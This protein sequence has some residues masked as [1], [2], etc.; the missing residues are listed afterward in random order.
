VGLD[1]T[2]GTVLERL[3]QAYIARGGNP[4]DISMFLA[5]D[6]DVD[7]SE[8]Q[9]YGGLVAPQSADPGA[10]G[11]YQG[12]WIPLW[13][14][15]PRRL[16][17]NRSYDDEV[18]EVSR[19]IHAAR[20]WIRQDIESLNDLEARILKQADLREQLQRERDE[21]LPMAVGGSALGLSF[22]ASLYARSFHVCNIVSTFDG[23]FYTLDVTGAPRVWDRPRVSGPNPPYP[24]LMD[25]APQ[26]E[27]AWTAIG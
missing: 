26:D 5:P 27:E 2:P 17:N 24:T 19:A 25:D 14:Y 15:P 3:L 23:V 6:S 18:V 12:G 11:T 9:P 22:D 7:G 20:E 16:G 21:I 8:T 13:R 1:V 10:A 4:F